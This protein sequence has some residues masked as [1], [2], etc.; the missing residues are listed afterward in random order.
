MAR[1]VGGSRDGTSQK[2]REQALPGEEHAQLCRRVQVRTRQHSR[3]WRSRARRGVTAGVVAVKKQGGA[4]LR[5]AG[6]RDTADRPKATASQPQH[7][8]RRSLG[9]D[10]PAQNKRETP[11]TEKRREPG[12]RIT[13]SPQL[14]IDRKRSR[15]APHGDLQ[16]HQCPRRGSRVQPR[17]ASA[18]AQLQRAHPRVSCLW[19]HWGW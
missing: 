7:L 3:G 16:P 2:P 8:P 11:G 19:G 12:S 1:V 10:T 13:F 17:P 9:S 5:R 4:V 15:T 6:D 18:S 14:K